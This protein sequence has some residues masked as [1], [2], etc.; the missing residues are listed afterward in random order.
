MTG[1]N[2]SRTLD[3]SFAGRPMETT[4]GV[5]TRYD[6]IDLALTDTYQRAFLSNVRS[7]KVGEAS[8]GIYAQNTVHWT[9][10]L[11]DHA[12]AGA[13]TTT[14]PTSIRSLMPTIP[15]TSSAAIGSPKFTDGAW[16]VQQDRIVLRRR[17][18]HAQQRRARRHHHR[19]AGRPDPEPDRGVIARRRSPLLVQTKGAEVGVRT[20]IVPGLDSS[21][22]VFI[23]DQ[24]SEIVFNGDAGDTS[25]SRPSRRYGV[26]W[27]N[28]Y[29]PNSWLDARRRSRGD[30][31]R[32]LSAT[33]ASRPRSMPRSPA[34]RRRRSA[35][36]PATTSPMRR[37][38]WPPPASRSARRPAG[39]APCAG[40]ISASSPLTEDNAFRSPATSIFNG[41]IGYRLDNGWRIQLDAL[42]LLNTR[43][44]QITYAYGSLIKTDSLYQSLLPGADRA[45]GGMPERRDGLCAASDRAVGG[46]AD[47]GRS[48]LDRRPVA[49]APAIHV[50]PPETIKRSSRHC[51]ERKRRSNPKPIRRADRLVKAPRC[52][53]ASSAVSAAQNRPDLAGTAL[54]GAGQTGA[55]FTS[56]ISSS[57]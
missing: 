41:R 53:F 56:A 50:L 40:A 35:T 39:S 42:N 5:Q 25:A 4:F 8:V 16:S 20:K 23:L 43:A 31:M 10:W 17:L 6:D 14:P 30:R 38:W 24:A 33:T 44:N 1:G 13:A 46:P 57:P 32:G 26:E 51:E 12:W 21:L 7:D 29:R 2:A 18:R 9:D 36:R 52:R 54:S 34:F 22:S 27:T 48:I 47:A 15:A 49:Y 55:A 45:G 11:Q 37:R 3:G 19:G 28:K